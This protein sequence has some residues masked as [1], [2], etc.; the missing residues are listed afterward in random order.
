MVTR[1]SGCNRLPPARS[2]RTTDRDWAFQGA[3]CRREHTA[4][5]A[6]QAALAAPRARRPACGSNRAF[7]TNH[8]NRLSIFIG[9]R[10]R[11]RRAAGFAALALGG[12]GAAWAGLPAAAQPQAACLST[13]DGYFRARLAARS[14]PTSTGPTAER[15]ARARSAAAGG[16]RLGFSRSR[17]ID[18]QSAV[19]VR[20]QRVTRGTAGAGGGCQSHAD[21]AGQQRRSTAPWENRA[22][23]WT[24][25]PATDAGAAYLPGRSPR[26][27]HA[28][29]ARNPR[30]GRGAGEPL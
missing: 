27:L 4:S 22:A 6:H 13:G 21:R 3:G 8:D 5:G 24:P 7:T 29:S 16:V 23:R 18:A 19:R 28:A 17:R 2:M 20:H 1:R 26:L 25:W 9:C 15:T 12:V 10:R 30:Q 11:A 14:M